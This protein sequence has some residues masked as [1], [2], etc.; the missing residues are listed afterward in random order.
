MTSI[1]A[2]PPASAFTEAATGSGSD[3]VSDVGPRTG[4]GRLGLVGAGLSL[5]AL[6]AL[7]LWAWLTPISG[8]VMASGQ[9]TVR[10]QPRAV[11][12]L[13]GGIVREIAVAN[14]DQVAAGAVLLRLDPSQI[15]ASLGIARSQLAETLAQVARLKAEAATLGDPGR[16]PAFTRDAIGAAPQAGLAEAAD[17]DRQFAAQARILEARNA[18]L[19]NQIAQQDERI[20]QAESQGQG[21]EGVIAA[22][23]EQLAFVARELETLNKLSD[24][25]LTRLTDVLDAQRRQSELTG[26]LASDR[27]QQAQLAGTRRDAALAKAQAEREFQEQVVTDLGE[28]QAKA[29]ELA[30]Q[31]STLGDQL[32]RVEIRAPVAG[33]VHELAP[34]G[35]GSVVTPGETVL[36]VVPTGEGIEIDLRLEPRAIEQVHPGQRARLVLPAFDSR[37]TPQIFGQIDRISATVV[38]DEATR[39]SYYRLTVSVPPEELARLGTR[40]LVPGMPVEAYLETGE[41]TVLDYLLHPVTTQIDRMFRER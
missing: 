10:G 19:V 36:Q 20:A 32:D 25:G 12:H 15:A 23:E 31:I 27:A 13:D 29:D 14:G 41:R 1:S 21:L 39:T 3:A 40:S 26:Q 22:R 33:I 38:T 30:L 4:L 7:L 17:L 35:T 37:T 9:A 28:A 24:R 6:G 8:A 34:T 16:H 5:G 18:V 2:L 11:Q